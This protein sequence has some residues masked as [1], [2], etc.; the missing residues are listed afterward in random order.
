MTEHVCIRVHRG[1][2]RAHTCAEPDRRRLG[3]GDVTNYSLVARPSFS[4][5]PDQL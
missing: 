1:V 3:S 5:G 2:A 4:G